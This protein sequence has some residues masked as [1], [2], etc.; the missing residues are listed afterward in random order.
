MG[1]KNRL[2]LTGQKQQGRGARRALQAGYHA[3]TVSFGRGPEEPLDRGAAAQAMQGE[4]ASCRA[5][6]VAR[7]PGAEAALERGHVLGGAELGH[8]QEGALAV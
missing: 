3:L 5:G 4:Q 8:D 2:Q 7:R 1:R 6:P